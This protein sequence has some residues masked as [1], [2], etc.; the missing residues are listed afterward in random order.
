M[1]IVCNPM[2]YVVMQWACRGGLR[3]CRIVDLKVSRTLMRIFSATVCLWLYQINVFMIIFTGFFHLS[4]CYCVYTNKC[5]SS[6]YSYCGL[7]GVV[8]FFP[9]YLLHSAI[10]VY[11]SQY[12]CSKSRILCDVPYASYVCSLCLILMIFGNP[13][14]SVC[15]CQCVHIYSLWL[16]YV[17]FQSCLLFRTP[18]LHLCL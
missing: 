6:L 1:V 14:M 15:I 16:L 5:K 13:S 8:D 17:C 10:T 9:Y 2:K 3:V 12:T 4:T 7:S 18:R 11:T